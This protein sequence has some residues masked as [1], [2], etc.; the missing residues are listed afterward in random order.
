MDT[1]ATSAEA[2]HIEDI[3]YPPFTGP[4]FATYNSKIITNGSPGAWIK[5]LFATWCLDDWSD[6]AIR[7]SQS[8]VP[9]LCQYIHPAARNLPQ[10]EKT[11]GDQQISPAFYR[12][13]LH[14]GASWTYLLHTNEEML[15][16]GP[17]GRMLQDSEDR[18]VLE[19]CPLC[20]KHGVQV[21]GDAYHYRSWECRDLVVRE[22]LRLVY[23]KVESC[24]KVWAPTLSWLADPT[25]GCTDSGTPPELVTQFPI[26]SH[27]G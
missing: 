7:K 25:T 20:M 9:S 27:I 17:C 13:A 26:L 21:R 18:L 22:A 6:T 19:M 5:T 15:L 12:H 24:L 8:T 4:C 2:I 16:L 11:R 1:L 10:L 14:L 23:H 3:S